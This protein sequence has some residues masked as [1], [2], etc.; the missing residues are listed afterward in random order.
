[1]FDYGWDI[2]IMDTLWK[3]VLAFLKEKG[4][5]VWCWEECPLKGGGCPLLRLSIIE[6][7]TVTVTVVRCTHV[8]KYIHQVLLPLS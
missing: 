5:N 4:V 7:F 3:S 8:L 6:C 1:M 2:L